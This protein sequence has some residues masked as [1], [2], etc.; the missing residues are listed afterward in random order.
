MTVRM[1]GLTSPRRE[2][3]D[4]HDAGRWTLPRDGMAADDRSGRF[5]RCFVHFGFGFGFVRFNHLLPI[6]SQ[7]FLN[8]FLLNRL[9]GSRLG[10]AI[11]AASNEAGNSKHKDE[12]K[13]TSPAARA[14]NGRHAPG[15]LHQELLFSYWQRDGVGQ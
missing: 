8:L 12:K 7:V 13:A 4:W 2:L 3:P 11:T 14:I 1:N 15:S 5:I 9:D 6:I 10:A